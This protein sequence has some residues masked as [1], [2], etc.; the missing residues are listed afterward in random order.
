MSDTTKPT[1]TTAEAPSIPAPQFPPPTAPSDYTRAW[2]DGWRAAWILIQAVPSG[3][4]MPKTA[5]MKLGCPVCG[6][7]SDGCPMGYVCPRNDCP[8]RVS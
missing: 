6:L 7:G 8:T 5:P 3:W 4:A 2:M 1:V